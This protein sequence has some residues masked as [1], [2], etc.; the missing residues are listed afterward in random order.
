M[1]CSLAL[2]LLSP[3]L[4]VEPKTETFK[5]DG[6]DRQ[7]LVYAPS[8]P[9]AHPPLVFAFHGHGGNMRYSARAYDL[10]TLWP[11]AVVVYMNGLPIAGIYD[12]GG[13][14][15]GWQKTV[16][17]VGDRDLHFFDAVY[18]SARKEFN[19]DSKRVYA[20]GHSNGA[21]FSYL[22]WAERGDKLAAIAPAAASI[23]QE[24]HHGMIPVLAIA[25][26]KDF[27]V[28]FRLQQRNVDR[29]KTML[30]VATDAKPVPFG[31]AQLYKGS[32]ADLG[33]YIHP[34]GHE[35]PEGASKLIVD[36]FKQHVK[37]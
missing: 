36:F 8:K 7:A 3:N 15:N 34:G 32:K 24:F 12:R 18:A 19:F 14:K 6:V 29:L 4:L 22:L 23:Q 5:V 35:Y 11:E 33:V 26:E 1:I 9:G 27:L 13:E 30:G 31:V 20:M 28:P 17:L 25:G 2:A 37:I 21:G 16:G 10:H